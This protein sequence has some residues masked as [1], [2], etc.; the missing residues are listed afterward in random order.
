MSLIRIE[1]ISHVRFTAPDLDEMERFLVSFGLTP[2]RDDAG[3]LLG[4]GSGGAPFLHMTEPG[5]PGFAAIG[6]RAASLEDLGVLAAAEGARVEDF[7]APGGGSVVRLTDPDGF[8]VEVV[9]GQA[10]QAPEAAA[11][12]AVRNTASGRPRVSSRV[13]VQAGPSRVVRLGHAVLEVSDFRVSEAWYKAR[14]GLLTSDEIEA[15]PGMA[16][17]AFFRCDRGETPTDHHT[18]FLLQGPGGARFNHAAFEVEN[19]DDLM[20]GH[21]HLKADG[22]KAAWG[23][24]RH[25]LGSQ[26]FDYW[27]DPWGHELEHWTDGDLFTAS[28]A[29]G[30]ASFT[31]LLGVQWGAAH[32]MMAQGGR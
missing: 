25:I 4:R 5:A 6:F 29:P 3:R 11:P 2:F 10:F 21:A 26:V 9:A 17:G 22:R 16:I 13:Q 12:E 24:G 32:P 7:D 15:A 30:K 28:D 18:L 8:Q 19:L 1:D 27:K 31:D 20:R 23:V 14:F